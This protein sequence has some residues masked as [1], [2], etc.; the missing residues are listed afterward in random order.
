MSRPPKYGLPVITTVS[1]RKNYL[2]S[3]SRSLSTLPPTGGWSFNVAGSPYTGKSVVLE[4]AAI[5]S[6]IG[7]PLSPNVADLIEIAAAVQVVDR[8]QRRPPSNRSGE[9]WARE[10]GLTLGVR[11]P[12]RWNDERVAGP[13]REL[14][15]WLTDDVWDL[16]FERRVAPAKSGEMVQFL[17]DVAPEGPAVALYSGGLDS[18]AGV[19][20]DVAAGAAPLLVTAIAN[21]RQQ[22]GQRQT[23]LGVERELGVA[24]KRVGVEFHLRGN[25]ARDN[26]HRSR[27]FGFL[28]IAA[29]VACIADIE[30]IRVYENG[31]GAINLPCTRAQSGAPATRSMHPESLRKAAAF[32][33]AALDRPFRQSLW[34]AGLGCIDQKTPYRVDILRAGVDAQHSY[35]LNAMLSQAARLD[36]AIRQVDPWISLTTAFPELWVGGDALA[37]GANLC[38]A[39]ER[40]VEMYRRYVSEWSRLPV[41]ELAWFFPLDRAA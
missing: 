3:R 24:L 39:R 8:L 25:E 31:I 35:N 16:R 28:A 1:L 37:N 21:R 23:I 29:A 27:G 2:M 14:L 30:T 11:N 6:S 40:L 12:A 38:D 34:G 9:C 26:S 15:A 19:V 17:F 18:L 13:M 10:I 22:Q 5:A 7:R 36:A 41:S 32:F 20:A 4:D 33:S